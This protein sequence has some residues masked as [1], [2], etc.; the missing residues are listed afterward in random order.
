MSVI[1]V[2]VCMMCDIN[3][4]PRMDGIKEE[5]DFQSLS[6]HSEGEQVVG[7][8]QEDKPVPEP[9]G[10]VKTEAY[11]SHVFNLC[12]APFNCVNSAMVTRD[13]LNVDDKFNGDRICSKCFLKYDADILTTVMMKIICNIFAITSKKEILT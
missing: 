2:M 5:L 3:F 11:V 1:I 6:G 4:Q 12:F 13:P 8:K 10:L 7:I 9:F